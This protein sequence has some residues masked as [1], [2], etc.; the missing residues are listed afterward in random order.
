VL[1]RVKRRLD[2]N[3]VYRVVRSIVLKLDEDGAVRASSA[4]AFDAFLS[5]IPLIAFAGFLLSRI[6]QSSNL[7]LG[8]LVRAAPPVVARAVEAEFARMAEYTAVAPISLTGFLWLSSA[9]VSTAMGVFETIYG[10][11]ERSWYVR[12]AIAAGCVL[13]SVALIPMFAGLGMLIGWLSG[14]IGDIVAFER[15]RIFPGAIATVVLWA[16]VSAAFSLYVARLARYA[17]FYGSLATTAI[18]LL[19]LW[20]LALGLMVG[21]EL[22]AR[23]ERERLGLASI[24]PR[25]RVPL[26]EAQ[27]IPSSPPLPKDVVPARD[28]PPAPIP[29]Q[30]TP[31]DETTL[32]SS[33]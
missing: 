28:T 5:L 14:P 21:G 15:R 30:R 9:G 27:R 23:L 6:H 3:H 18:F 16:L 10:A 20:L 22:N 11:R 26:P 4:I 25:S 32:R 19:W 8:P 17:T 24:P 2:R 13:A 1:Q 12:R 33:K 31:R 29:A 7:I